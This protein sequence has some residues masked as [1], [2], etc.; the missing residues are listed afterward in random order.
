MIEEITFTKIDDKLIL[1][2][3]ARMQEK[4]ISN[5][6]IKNNINK[7]IDTIRI[8]DIQMTVS[9]IKNQ[10]NRSTKRSLVRKIRIKSLGIFLLKTKH[11]L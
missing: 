3:I 1:L 11:N 5:L 9:R 2:L 6:E 4:T 8:Q 10:N 7:V